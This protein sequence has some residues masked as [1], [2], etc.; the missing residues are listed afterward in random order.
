LSHD[1]GIHLAGKSAYY[2]LA[3]RAS[4]AYHGKERVLFVTLQKELAD[5]LIVG[6]L[7]ISVYPETMF[8]DVILRSPANSWTTKNLM[9]SAGLQIFFA[10]LVLSSAKGSE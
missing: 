6:K 7:L 10:E 5:N 4:R 8:L 1:K 3:P 9:V 2:A